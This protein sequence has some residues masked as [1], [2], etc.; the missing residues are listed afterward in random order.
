MTFNRPN[1]NHDRS[2]QLSLKLQPPVATKERRCHLVQQW[3]CFPNRY[4]RCEVQWISE[5][6]RVFVIRDEAVI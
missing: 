1:S 4:P 5:C 2:L 6:D 3:R